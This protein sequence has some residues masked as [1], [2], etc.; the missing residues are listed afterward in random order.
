MSRTLS[1][2]LGATLL[3]WIPLDARRLLEI[4]CGDGA[5]G[6]AYKRRNPTA[7]YAG[8]ERPGVAAGAARRLDRLFEGDFENLDAALLVAEGA[9]DAV[10]VDGGLERLDDLQG[11]LERLKAL[12]VPGGHLIVSVRNL[13][14]WAPMYALLQGQAPFDEDGK[15]AAERL[16]H[17][18]L[19][20]LTGALDQAGLSGVK[21]RRAMRR[22][23]EETGE[24]LKA[25]L[26]QVAAALELDTGSLQHR[27]DATHYVVACRRAAEAP[28]QAAHLSLLAAAPSF[29]DVRTRLPAEQLETLPGLS[30]NY[31]ERTVSLPLG[32]SVHPKILLQQRGSKKDEAAWMPHLADLIARE[33][34]IITEFDD[35]PDLFR[36]L[37]RGH[38]ESIELALSAA[39]AIQTSTPALEEAFR[40][41]NPETRRFDNALFSLGPYRD[42]SAEPARVF[43]GAL[44]RERFSGQVA[45]ALTPCVEANPDTEFVVVH[46]KAFFQALPTRSKRFLPAMPYTDYLRTMAQCHIA[47][48]PL[49]GTFGERFKSDIKFLE[50]AGAGVAMIASPPVYADTIVDGQTGLIAAAVEDWPGALSRLLGDPKLRQRLAR[51]AWEYVRSERMFAYQAA[52]RRDWYLDLWER[53]AELTDALVAR[54]PILKAHLARTL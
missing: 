19:R 33:W 1:A 12:L 22:D 53:R 50:A 42:R 41:T 2:K 48:T 54:H 25:A 17:F 26:T 14:H 7:F 51:N 35:H 43:Y 39:H 11:S 45:K 32:R 5:L 9:F 29:L 40:Q 46:D 47:L 23:T 21:T 38:A 8:V 31:G 34:V 3:K 52:A 16:R 37:G 20:S 6:E 30:V 28:R 18:T 49:E 36:E 4:D 27:T 13:G 10:I 15:P 44:N 24:R